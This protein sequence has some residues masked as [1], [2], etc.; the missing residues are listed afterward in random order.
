MAGLNAKRGGGEEAS[1]EVHKRF[2]S[3]DTTKMLGETIK[4]TG[5][6]LSTTV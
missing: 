6:I 1:K 3:R 5:P 4:H 2:Q